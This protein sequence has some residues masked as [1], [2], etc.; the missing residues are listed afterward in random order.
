MQKRGR[1]GNVSWTR[2]GRGYLKWR[3]RGQENVED[4][5]EEDEEEEEVKE[6]EVKEEEEEVEGK[7]GDGERERSH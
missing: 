5:N 7:A 1:S 6:E 3:K 4:E 2:K